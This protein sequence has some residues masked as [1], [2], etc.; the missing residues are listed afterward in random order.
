MVAAAAPVGL[1]KRGTKRAAPEVAEA[2]ESA[3]PARKGYA[4]RKGND[5]VLNWWPAPQ[6]L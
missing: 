3:A 2:E 5:D 1:L 6:Q 4:R